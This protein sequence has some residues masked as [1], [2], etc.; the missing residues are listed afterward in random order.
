MSESAAGY[1]AKR[2]VQK[3]WAPG[4]GVRKMGIETCI[5]LCIRS[6]TL[7]PWAPWEKVPERGKQPRGAAVTAGH[8]DVRP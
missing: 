4:S 8:K 7:N 5:L 6:D 3:P 2:S 1:V